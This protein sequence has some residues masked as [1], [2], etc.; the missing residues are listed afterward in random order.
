MYV[1]RSLLH[2][3]HSLCTTRGPNLVLHIWNHG[4]TQL[5]ELEGILKGHLVQTPCNEQAHL[6]L[7]QV[8]QSPVQLGLIY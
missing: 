2:A 6:H 3:P 5:F 7:D 1:G 4:I 8:A